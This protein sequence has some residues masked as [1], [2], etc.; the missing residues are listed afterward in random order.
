MSSQTT[1]QA[2]ALRLFIAQKSKPEMVDRL[3]QSLLAQRRNGMWQNSYDNAQA[4]TALVEYSQLQPKPANFVAK[5]QLGG[6]NLGEIR[7][8]SYHNLS[9]DVKIPMAEL[10]RGRRDLL[11][12]K[13][14]EGRL[15]Y[16]AAY[17]YRLQGNQPGRFNGL[18][19]TREVRG[20]GSGENV[21]QKV[22]LYA[23]DKPLSLESGQVFDVGLEII[24]DHP[25]EHVVINDPLAA[26]LEAVDA[27]F[28]TA[29]AALQALADSW[30]VGFKTI[31][32]DRI[33]AYADHLDPGVY[34]LHY[35][36]RSVTPGTF[37]WPG[38]E[39][40]LQYAPEEFGRAADST[41]VVEGFER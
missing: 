8:D 13:S 6:K 27:S 38:A 14:G 29:T 25:V 12:Q 28:Q 16:L 11:L 32:R 34:S 19:V 21:L 2:Q 10:P 41:L 17:R 5:V 24:V 31:Y 36:V 9:A 39:V 7:F 4:L 3:L 18:R 15:H 1:A 30:E 26:G 35:L 40:R 20:V 33:V 23:K 22:G 37:L